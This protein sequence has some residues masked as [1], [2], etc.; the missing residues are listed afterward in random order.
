M[1]IGCRSALV[2]QRWRRTLTLLISPLIDGRFCGALDLRSPPWSLLVVLF[3]SLKISGDLAH[4]LD[5]AD[6]QLEALV[7]GG[8]AP[9]TAAC[10]PPPHL[11]M[12]W[13]VASR[14]S[15]APLTPSLAA[16]L[17]R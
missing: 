13:S 6:Q 9:Q 16:T 10:A 4:G 3:L 7:W 12:R 15:S 5:H 17:L 11:R 14:T 1:Q 8:A 2:M